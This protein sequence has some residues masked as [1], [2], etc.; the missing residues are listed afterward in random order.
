MFDGSGRGIRD[1]ESWIL[2]VLGLVLLAFLTVQAEVVSS[3]V[4]SLRRF[5]VHF[6]RPL[7]PTF[8][9]VL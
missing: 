1:L 5:C 8:S 3:L 2:I 7:I 6:L 9:L 4:A